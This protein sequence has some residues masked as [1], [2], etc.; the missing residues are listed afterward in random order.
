MFSSTQDVIPQ[1]ELGNTFGALFFGVIFATLLVHHLITRMRTKLSVSCRHNI[2]WN[3]LFGITN[4]QAFIYFQTHRGTGMRHYKPVVLLL[5]LL[6]ALHLALVVHGIYHYLVTNYANIA[7]L[8]DLVWSVK[9]QIPIDTLIILGVHLLYV[10]RI[11]IVSRGRSR[12]LPI[13]V[14]ILVVLSSGVAVALNWAVFRC[15]TFEDLLKIDW[16]SYLTLGT[17]SFLDII[18]ASSLCYLLATSRTGFSSTDSFVTKL[19]GYTIST[20]CMTS[21]FSL[22]AIIT[23][24]VMPKNFVFL[25]VEFLVAKLYVNSYMALLN[26]RY[27]L[28]GNTDDIDSFECHN[29]HGVYRPELRLNVLQGENF[30]APR[31]NV[32]KQPG[33][34]VMHLTRPVQAAMRPIAVTMEMGSSSS[35]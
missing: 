14:G 12:A 27:Y 4:V 32:L 5:W 19:M 13:T 17:L 24:A 11:W 23:C 7:A 29:C 28:Q 22:T 9:L 3:S 6:D 1:L 21:I 2:S 20:G 33:D 10:H 31:K 16:A 30:P 34:G 26:A 15:N 35:V 8:S 18:I 25:S